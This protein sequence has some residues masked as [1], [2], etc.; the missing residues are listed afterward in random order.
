MS[1]N[2][3]LVGAFVCATA[4]ALLSA[5]A[6]IPAVKDVTADRDGHMQR[7]FAPQA[8][9]PAVLKK[10]PAEAGH[11]GPGKLTITRI[12]HSEQNDGKKTSWKSVATYTD[13]GNG[14]FERMDEFSSNDIPTALYFALSYKGIFDLRWQNVPLQRM[15]AMPLYEVKE[16]TRFDSIPAAMKE[17]EWDFS[18][19][20]QAQI[21]NYLASQKKCKAVRRIAASEIYRSLGGQATEIDCETYANNSVQNRTKYMLLEQYGVG[22]L[23]E[24]SSSVNKIVY[25]ITDVKL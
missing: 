2:R 16:I 23:T 1:N 4:L 19:G 24:L 18:T 11:A 10:V 12:A 22:V 7:N 25:E 6:P 5:C 21:A 14:L 15:R 9:N 20:P 3:I 8:V 17:F 13:V